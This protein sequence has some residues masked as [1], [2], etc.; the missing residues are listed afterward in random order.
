MRVGINAQLLYLSSSYR[1]AGINR[2][3]HRLLAHLRPLACPE[4][5]LVVYTARW[6]LPPELAPTD[7][8]HVSQTRLPTWRPP[9]RIAWEQLLQPGVVASGRLDLL[10]S[11]S[12]VQPLL[13]PVPSV[14]T[15]LDLSFLRMPGSFNRGNRIYLSAMS[16]LSARRSDRIVTISESTR[17]DVIEFFGVHPDKVEAIHCG[18][19]PRFKP[20]ED[21][22]LLSEFRAAHG[23]PDH[24]LLYLGTLEPRKN[25][26]RLVE[27]YALG[28]RRH[29]VRQKLILG[30]ARGWLYDRIFARVQALGLQEEVVFANYIPEHELPLWYNCADIFIYPSLYEGFG[31]PPLEAMAC[32]TPVITSSVSSLPEVVGTAAITVDPLDVDAL[33]EAIAKVLDN[34]SLGARLSEEGRIQAARFS[35]S[36]MAERTLRLYRSV[37]EREGR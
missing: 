34:R 31:L 11:T 3:I 7:H 10:H 30:G 17:R 33:A 21:S 9:V 20:V 24:F 28:R 18:V 22:V 19:D 8:F 27:A 5:E 14:V 12:Y 15:M 6:T 32:G 16:A 4:Q 36:D 37:L 2:Y 25:V 29:A 35:W 26:E 1:A 23:L 13:C